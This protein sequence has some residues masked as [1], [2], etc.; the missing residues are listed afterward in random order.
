[1]GQQSRRTLWRTLTTAATVAGMVAGAA[2]MAMPASATGAIYYI[3]ST[4]GSDSN[5][6]TSA[7]APWQ[8]LGK[9]SQS[10]FS[11]G[12]Q[13]LFKGGSQWT[14]T[15][16]FQ[17][18]G[19]PTAPVVIG[20]YGTGMPRIDGAT[21]AV[22]AVSLLNVHDVVVQ[23][24]EVTNSTNLAASNNTFYRGIYVEG[25]DIG[26]IPGI[27][28]QNN[29][30][31]NIDGKGNSGG[32]GAGGIAV[33]VRGNTTPTW[34][35]GLKISNNEVSN[36]NAY[37]IST[38]TTWCAGCEIYPAETGIPTSE[39]SSQRKAFAAP[40]ISDN[41]VHDVTG[42]GITPQYSDD[43]LVQYNTVDRAASHQLLAGGGNVG[44]W[45]QGT[46]RITVQYN[47]VRRTAVEGVYSN[48]DGMAFDA[49]M[50]TS[51]ST[52]QYNVSDSN[53]G[54]FF[55]CLISAYNNQVRYNI[56]LNDKRRVFSLWSGCGNTRAYN[57]TIW[58]SSDPTPTLTTVGGPA[59]S[60]PQEAVTRSTS[61]SHTL[62]D[63]IFYN[64]AGATFR[65]GTDPVTSYSHN[66]YWSPAGTPVTA[67]NDTSAVIADPLLNNPQVQLPA[68]GKVTPAQLTAFATGFTPSTQSPVRNQG[69]SEFGQTQDILGNQVPTGAA[70]LGAIQHPV[71]A[72]ATTTL[73]TSAGNI[74]AVSDGNP[75]S[76]WAS[77]NSPALPGSVTIQYS[78]PRT[79]DAVTIAAAFGLGQ[80]PTSVNIDTWDG[81]A[82][83]PAVSNAAL[84]WHQNTG[85]V[86]SLR[87]HL[88]QTVTTTQL[89]VTLNAGNLTWGH[90]AINEI[91]ASFQGVAATSLGEL[92][93][94]NNTAALTDG[95]P[96][97]SWA[98]GSSPSL[99]GY[100]QI[101]GPAQTVSSVTLSAAFGQGQ[102]P[103][104]V[105]IQAMNG[106]N[107]IWQTILPS[108]AV[109][110][111]TNTSTVESR[112]LTLATPITATRFEIHIESANLT[113]GHVALNGVTLN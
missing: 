69:V 49:D 64:P 51:H 41:F 39:V 83:Q 101:D 8:S 27:V 72:T 25:K 58:G 34:Y 31:H 74:S 107:G 50:G 60:Q 94:Q 78:D 29:Y 100:L 45:W 52:V 85:A 93:A 112:T 106:D 91:T 36:V 57:N 17:S 63:N 79:F 18:S 92:A 4:A 108:T 102:G 12:D 70:D 105:S 26:Q 76:S 1:M 44:I 59:G 43:A 38:F 87:V 56:S 47:V 86:E 3:D 42:G 75:A 23:G 97:T 73:G 98:S 103:T 9:V 68:E 90:L 14:G 111:S 62:A 80:G 40:V 15:V 54:G 37:G 95:N 110:W 48:A 10:S 46:D 104:Q 35:S 65:Y 77:G 16:T 24:L 33:G 13:I 30:V 20:S 109:S 7:S 81:T 67:A 55:M 19:T 84:A 5:A 11:P 21:Q 113:W 61:S 82:W 88:P 22:S 89:R 71:T 6:G 96:A 66:L 99:P 2:V 32:I 53:N 28:I